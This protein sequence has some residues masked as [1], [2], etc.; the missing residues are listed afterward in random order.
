M[1]KTARINLAKQ[2]S[3][4]IEQGQYHNQNQELVLVRPSITATLEG[5]IL[6]LENDFEAAL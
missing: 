1:K 3:S 4:I 5:G 6:Y 2:T